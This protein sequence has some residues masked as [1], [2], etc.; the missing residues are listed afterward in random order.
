MGGSSTKQAPP[1]TATQVTQLPAFVQP[2]AQRYLDR[3]EALSQSPFQ[4]YQGTRISPLNAVHNFALN[5]ARQQFMPQ[6]TGAATQM[7]NF[8]GGAFNEPA[9]IH[10]YLGPML[11]MQSYQGISRPYPVGPGGSPGGGGKGGQ[12]PSPQYPVQPGFPSGPPDPIT[13][14]PIDP[15]QPT[16]P[17][18]PTPTTLGPT[19]PVSSTGPA[20]P[21]RLNGIDESQLLE[22]DERDEFNDLAGPGDELNFSFDGPVD[23]VTGP[24]GGMLDSI[25]QADAMASPLS[26]ALPGAGYLAG[27]LLENMGIGTKG[28]FGASQDS[29]E[30]TPAQLDFTDPGT[31]FT[32]PF[33]AFSGFPGG[34]GQDYGSSADYS[35]DTGLNA[36]Y[37]TFTGGTQEDQSLYTPAFPD[38]VPVAA[39]FDQLGAQTMPAPEMAPTMPAPEQI[40]DM[41]YG[42]SLGYA[43]NSLMSPESLAGYESAT[44]TPAPE[45][46]AKPPEPEKVEDM[47]YG[48]SLGYAPNSLTSFT[49]PPTAPTTT[50]TQTYTAPSTGMF[51]EFGQQDQKTLADLVADGIPAE[52]AVSVAKAQGLLT[53]GLDATLD[54]PSMMGMMDALPGVSYYGSN[55]NP[56]ETFVDFSGF[57]G[58]GVDQSF[59]DPVD[60]D[61]YG[62]DGFGFD[63]TGGFEF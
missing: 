20:S 7:G 48:P 62:D 24:F 37:S 23:Q 2:T 21:L 45:M 54:P 3:A 53:D 52:H 57:G 63:A 8:M 47:A 26:L 31:A 49:T 41:N 6:M 28:A 32:D 33:G 30:D 39:S 27:N 43:P 4:R 11:P 15:T 5:Q 40:E 36:P 42:P 18:I 10:P 51:S 25:S 58:L 60:P 59:N 61:S 55:T 50:Q 1:Q 16:F 38:N 13:G 34:Y 12:Q 22:P 9:Y 14:T 46:A 35:Y 29:F 17:E 56:G 19:A 44:T